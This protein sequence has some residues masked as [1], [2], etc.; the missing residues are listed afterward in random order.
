VVLQQESNKQLIQQRLNRFRI[1]VLLIFLILAA[2]MWQLQIIQGSEYALRAEQNRIRTIELVAPRGAISDRNHVP[3]VENRPSFNVLLY[4]ESMKDQ[5]A[6]FRFLTQKLG[7]RKEDIEERFQRS[8]RAGIYRPIV[9]KEDAGM[10]D[11]SIIEAHKAIH[12]EIEVGY[13]PRRL[14]HYDNLAAHLLGYVGEVNEEELD[15]DVFPGAKPGSLVGRRGVERIYN[16]LLVGKDGERQVLVDSMGREVGV[17]DEDGKDPVI[18]N[19]VRLTLDLNLQSV[20]EKEMKGRVGAIVAMDPRNG[21]ILVMVSSPS[22]NPNAFSARMSQ[23]E[24]NELLNNPDDPMQ[25]RAIQNS[26][27]PGS[28]FKLIMADA[29]LEEGLFDRDLTVTCK[30]SAVFYGRAYGCGSEEGHGPLKLEQALAKS[31]NIFFYELG[32]RLGIEKIAEHA[33]AFGLGEITGIDLPGERS[34]LMP[35]P[36]WKRE[37]RG[38]RWYPGETISVAIGQGAVSTTPLQ[39]LRAVSAIATGGL[40]TT[41]HVLLDAENDS[42]N[43]REWPV[44]R[45]PMK[46]ENVRRIREGMWQSVNNWGTGYNA[47]V[48]GQAICG[49]TGTAQVIGNDSKQQ[50][51]KELED[52]SWFVGFGNKDNPEIAVVVFVE[53]GGKGGVTAAPMAQKIFSAYFHK[54]EPEM[55]TDSGDSVHREAES[56]VY[57]DASASLV[58][59]D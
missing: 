35:S 14:Y 22:F 6:T 50:T 42:L 7:V 44:R 47:A 23:D 29:G 52:H 31:C 58:Q 27:S 57:H 32:R 43:E 30:G 55:L 4:R 1:P 15:K 38:E 41:P 49:K 28:V 5:E 33:H 54:D 25:N 53:H 2:R 45:I 56:S 18:G 8:Q 48:P 3:L 36:E 13:E 9:I 20:A 19:E 10:A 17:P 34:G 26:H 40:I 37:A 24:W 51:G 16:N 11:V 12:P 21:E 59:D 39:I 46:D